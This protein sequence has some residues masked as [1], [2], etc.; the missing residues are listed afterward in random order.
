VAALVGLGAVGAAAGGEKEQ[1]TV[2]LAP[3]TTLATIPATTAV[4]PAT[5]LAPVTVP[6]TTVPP[7]TASPA[8]APPATAA[9]VTA[10]PTTDDGL[11]PF[12]GNSPEDQLMPDLMC[13]SLQEAQNEIQDH[14][15]FFSRSEDATGQGRM[16]IVDSNWQVVGQNPAAGTPIG[17]FEAVL[18]VVKFGEPSPCG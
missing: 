17:E 12:G 2:A 1:T 7:A 15:V 13:M 11:N 4:I 16:Q 6:A 5:T 9:P 3:S 18:F 8:T 10:P 14:G